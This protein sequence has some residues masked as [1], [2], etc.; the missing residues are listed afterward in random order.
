MIPKTN[1]GSKSGINKKTGEMRR[2][3]Y[4]LILTII[5]FTISIQCSTSETTLPDPPIEN[6][7]PDSD[8]DPEPT[9]KGDVITISGNLR[10]EINLGID[11]ERLWF[12]RSY[13]KDEV[14]RLSVSEMKSHF[15]RVAIPCDYEREE[16]VLKP[17]AY[18][19]IREMMNAMKNANPEIKFFASPRPLQE[20]YSE[21]ERAT[22]WGNNSVPWSPYP[23]WIQ[24]WDENGTKV[25]DGIV[26]TQWEKGAFHV[27]KLVRYYAD[28][29]NLMKSEGFDITYMDLSNEQTI[30]TPAHAK[31]IKDNLPAKLNAGINMPLLIAPSTWS[32]EG[33]INWLDAINTANGEQDG[34]DIASVHNTGGSGSFSEF[35]NKAN[36]RGKEVWNTEMH[37]WVGMELKQEILTSEI[38][39]EHM[40]AGFNAIDTWLFFGNYAGR[41]HSMLWI[42]PNNRQII[43]TGKYEIFKK[44]VNNANGGRY[45]DI[46]TTPGLLT[47]AF[48][49]DAVLSVW[50]LNKDKDGAANTII[51]LPD[52]W[53]MLNNTI[54][55][56]YWNADATTNE[57][58]NST[59][60][61]TE[62]N[63]FHS[64]LMGESLYFFRMNVKSDK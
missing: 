54:E 49:K 23:R 42:H 5:I 27:D 57:G 8:P 11:A 36:T 38:L 37:A 59:T 46:S 48:I 63:K 58:N 16:G 52:N 24:E 30:I 55:V 44:L 43:K 21:E 3:I 34:F 39:W 28:Y 41:D 40:R 9:P 35:V 45:V 12:W 17:D 60:T 10:Q 20:A 29:L 62:K 64:N 32:V 53:E 7:D 22:I 56:I 33:G 47:A 13:I 6:P 25:V 19:M 15:V 51:K 1:S 50:I 14:A 2:N 61:M 4:P 31:Y 18:D 26:V